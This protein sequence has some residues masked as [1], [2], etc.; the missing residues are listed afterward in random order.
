MTKCIFSSCPGEYD[1]FVSPTRNTMLH[2]QPSPSSLQTA[3][4]WEAAARLG[5]TTHPLEAWAVLE[6]LR[7][8]SEVKW[9]K[10]CELSEPTGYWCL[11]PAQ[12]SLTNSQAADKAPLAGSLTSEIKQPNQSPQTSPHCIQW[13]FNSHITKI[14]YLW[15]DELLT[16]IS[17]FWNYYIILQISHSLYWNHTCLFRTFSLIREHN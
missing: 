10:G 15:K 7:K 2:Y 11:L 14:F 4:S 17:E 3:S 12:S 9:E 5:S 8:S 6:V 1:L 16:K 13:V